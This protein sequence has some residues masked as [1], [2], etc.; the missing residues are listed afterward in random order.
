MITNINYYI[1]RGT[2]PYENLAVEKYLTMHTQPGQCVLYL[3]QNEKTVVIGK[4]QNAWKECKNELLEEDG[5]H[6]ARR[7][8]GG[9]AVFHDMGNL[10][11][12]FCVRRDDYDVGRQLG[13]IV[14]AVR[15]LGI[16]AE[17]SGRNDVTVDGRKISGNAFYRCGDFCYH[18]GTILI[19]VD[20]Q[21]M[22]R[23]LNVSSQKLKS[24]GVDSVK[25]RVVNL[26]ECTADP[27]TVSRV[28]EEM[29]AAFSEC[30]GLTAQP[31]EW[32]ETA[33]AS[34]LADAAYFASWEWKYGQKIAFDHEMSRRF[35]WGDVDLQLTVDSGIITAVNLYSDAMEQAFIEA[36]KER[37]RHQPYDCRA[38]VALVVETDAGMA[39][40]LPMVMEK[41]P[42]KGMAGSSAPSDVIRQMKADI[43]TLLESEMRR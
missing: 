3:W 40:A 38:L 11:F 2:D 30:Y 28:R 39:G 22:G 14:A 8:S 26:R 34:I 24:K 7:L 43:C 36:L 6:L 15:R 41:A 10:N 20:K 12:T 33:Q 37:L 31:F 4:N 21:Q 25:A 19:D 1:A 27:V 42:T 5:G 29:L 16:S 18:H 35:A 23:Y 32:P 17:I 9:G 13:V